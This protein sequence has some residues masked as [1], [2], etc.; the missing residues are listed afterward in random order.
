MANVVSISAQ[1]PAELSKI[2]DQ[3]SGE[4]ERS[5]SY[6]VKKGL[7]NFLSQRQQAL[8]LEKNISLSLKQIKEGDSHEVNDE[9]W[10]KLK[11][12]TIAEIK[13]KN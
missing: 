13:N 6:Y 7:E 10:K 11:N 9:F 4:E 2:L 12:E 8:Q 1:I 5:K 3:I